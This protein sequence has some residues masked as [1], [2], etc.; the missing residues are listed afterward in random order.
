MKLYSVLPDSVI[1]R[2]RRVRVDLDFRNV[3]RMMELLDDN[4]LMPD[5]R[6]Y[7][8]A[9]CFVK[10]TRHPHELLVE[11]RKLLFIETP[12]K[13]SGEKRPKITDFEQ[14]AGMIRAAFRQVYG[15]DLWT[16]KLHWLA[17]VDLLHNLPE[18]NRYEETLG[19]RAR[20]I[21]SPTKYNSAEREWLI[22]AKANVALDIPEED[23]QKLY[24]AQVGDVFAGI[25][26]LIERGGSDA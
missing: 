25:M 9:R 2:G 19:I 7:W 13:N 20:P 16:D 10:H 17:F 12:R 21:P 8:A 11:V 14:D 3:L 26:G 1:I 5:A 15:I 6:E 4:T 23:K 18:G 22:K 24:E